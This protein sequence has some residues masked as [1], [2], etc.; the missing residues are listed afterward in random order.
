MNTNLQVDSDMLLALYTE[1]LSRRHQQFP[2][3]ALPQTVQVFLDGED[4]EPT[5]VYL[6]P[7]KSED[8]MEMSA[9]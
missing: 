3:K 9:E 8:N 2:V 5:K 6:E 1:E 7:D 4:K